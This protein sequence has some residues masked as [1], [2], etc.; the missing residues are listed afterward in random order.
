MRIFGSGQ[1]SYLYL[2]GLAVSREVCLSDGVQLLPA[3][4]ECSAD[5]FLGLGKSDMDIS[6]ISLFLPLVQSQLRVTGADAKDT[7]IRSWNS[8]WDALLLGAV[9]GADVVCNLQSDVPAEELVPSSTVSVTNYHLRGLSEKPAHLTDADVEWIE[10]YF[11]SATLLMKEEVYRNAAH[12]LATYHW[13]SLPRARLAILWAGIEGLFSVESELVFR[14]SLYAAKFLGG[15]DRQ[16]ELRL[17]D[18]VK[19]LYKLRSKAVH[20]GRIKG[21]PSAAVHHSAQ[22]LQSLVRKCAERGELPNPDALV[23]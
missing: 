20:G 4:T 12:C 1:S 14:I 9:T 7:A 3:K 17:F 13:H 15:A 8:L 11:T 2:N 18:Q 21:N 23:P 16:E 19:E 6:I 5:L 10:Q 22:L